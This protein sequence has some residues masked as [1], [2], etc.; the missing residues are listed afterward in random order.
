MNFLE[1]EDGEDVQS[2]SQSQLMEKS[3]V[4]N[5][6]L[7]YKETGKGSKINASFNLSHL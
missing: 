2:C 4:C 7:Y 1:V 5:E 6:E 3:V